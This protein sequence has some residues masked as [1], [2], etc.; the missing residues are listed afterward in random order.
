MDS[1]QHSL[2]AHLLVVE[3]VIP[4]ASLHLLQLFIC[5]RIDSNLA[6]L[7]FKLLSLYLLSL[8]IP[9]DEA[10]DAELILGGVHLCFHPSLRFPSPYLSIYR[11]F[12]VDFLHHLLEE[13][14]F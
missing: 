1:R 13:H 3:L 10:F 6:V 14:I 2:A 11:A 9:K 8:L 4:L 12:C 7:V 5:H